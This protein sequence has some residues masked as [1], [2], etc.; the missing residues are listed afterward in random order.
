[1]V[2][3]HRLREMEEENATLCLQVKMQG[4]TPLQ[5]V[6]KAVAQRQLIMSRLPFLA[7]YGLLSPNVPFAITDIE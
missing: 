4:G 5:L 2:V 6:P 7:G 3:H 1:M